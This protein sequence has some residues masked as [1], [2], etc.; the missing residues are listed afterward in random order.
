MM[1]LNQAWVSYL[2][3]YHSLKA[4]LHHQKTF[5]LQYASPQLLAVKDL[6]LAVPGT[7]F[8]ALIFFISIA[9]SSLL[10]FLFNR[11]L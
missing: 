11:H 10:G 9:L 3:V 8:A 2:K 4:T 7:Y 5:D 1:D 6:E